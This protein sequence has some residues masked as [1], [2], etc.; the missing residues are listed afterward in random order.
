MHTER[1]GAAPA[2]H[3]AQHKGHQQPTDVQGPGQILDYPKHRNRHQ[4]ANGTRRTRR[5]ATAETEGKKV[6]GVG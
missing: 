1:P 3:H 6:V 2:P 5:Q 4:S